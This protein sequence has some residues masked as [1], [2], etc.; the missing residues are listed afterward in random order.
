MMHKQA[1][2]DWTTVA[3]MF[4]GGS[5]VGA[6]TGAAL[7]FVRHMQN[8]KEKAKQEEDTAKDDDI[9]YLNLPPKK[10]SD[11]ASAGTFAL[12][13]MAGLA[14]TVMAYNM[15]RSMYTKMRRK[16][17]QDE[18]DKE[19]QI[20]LGGLSGTAD[21]MSKQSSQFSIMS[22]GIG[23]AYLAT[24][25]T[26]LGS[27]V[28]ANRVLQKHFPP[29]KSPTEGKP[30]KIVVRTQRPNQPP[31]EEVDTP[32]EVNPDV[33]ENLARV[34]LAAKEA[35]TY[36][37]RERHLSL[38][39]DGIEDLVCAIASGR[40]DEIR[41]NI[42]AMGVNAT[43]DTVKGAHFEKLASLD[44]DAA[45]TVMA[46]DPLISQAIA[47]LLASSFVDISMGLCKVA[48]N[49]EARFRDDLVGLAK[50]ATHI[51]RQ[52]IAGAMV[53]EAEVSEDIP[54]PIRNLF[55]AH[56]LSN[57]MTAY[58][59]E[60]DRKDIM[61][62]N[63]NVTASEDSPTRKRNPTVEAEDDKALKFLQRNG[64][65]IDTALAKVA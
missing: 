19:Q 37:Q 2:V 23:G 1:G 35:A 49:I 24:L 62:I 41:S 27:A 14:G 55:V 32:A 13:G 4:A 31:E 57:I 10:A 52:A 58:G 60:D 38:Q 51:E 3:K 11:S 47:P 50:A 56:T 20:Y 34:H 64:K 9:L 65:S 30:R 43:M 8:L 18:L 28:I 53:K 29:L 46:N 22:K 26:A 63:G 25:L 45:V 48:Q 5:L 17:V 12:G 15:V 39:D 44:R 16:Q 36:D 21:P 54:G 7:S 6:G 61:Q 42:Q 33:V 40:G 59:K